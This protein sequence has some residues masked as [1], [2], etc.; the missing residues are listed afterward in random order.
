MLTDKECRAAK[1]GQ[2]PVKLFDA[3]GLHLLISTTGHKAGG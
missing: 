2:K 1:A 3:H